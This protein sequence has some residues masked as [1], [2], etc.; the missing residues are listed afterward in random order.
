[1]SR[2][3]CQSRIGIRALQGSQRRKQQD[4]ITKTGKTDRQ[5][6]HKRY[7]RMMP[8]DCVCGSVPDISEIQSR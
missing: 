2:K 6:V 4:N 7:G 3:E 8:L 1:M 5:N